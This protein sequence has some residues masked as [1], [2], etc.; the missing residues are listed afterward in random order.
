MSSWIDFKLDVEF[1]YLYLGTY[2]IK[3]IWYIILIVQPNN[4]LNW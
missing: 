1:F 2:D 3:L 4:M